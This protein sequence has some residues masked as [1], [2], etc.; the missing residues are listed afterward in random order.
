MRSPRGASGATGCSLFSTGMDSPVSADSWSC[1]LLVRT[2][3]RSA[4]TL[5]PEARK[6]RSPGT[7]SSAGTSRRLPSRCTL[8]WS[9]SILRMASSAASALPSW[10]KPMIALMRTTPRMTPVSTHSPSTAVTTEAPSSTKMRTLVNWLKKR[11][12]AERRFGGVSRLRPKT[13][14]RRRTSSCVSPFDGLSSSSEVSSTE[15]ECQSR[16]SRSFSSVIRRTP[17]GSVDESCRSARVVGRYPTRR[18]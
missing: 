12:D 15:R 9:E 2:S 18:A 7:S 16:I 10:M 11:A 5:S 8:A 13:S 3:R 6:T 17:P 4:G 1:R 14:S